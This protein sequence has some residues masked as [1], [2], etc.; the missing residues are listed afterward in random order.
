MEENA[1]NYNTK[2]GS[3]PIIRITANENHNN[4]PQKEPSSPII[5]PIMGIIRSDG[6]YE[7]T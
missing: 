5:K 6:K 3:D 2:T 1:D 4:E 7:D